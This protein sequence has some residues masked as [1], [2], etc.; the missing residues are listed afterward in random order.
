MHLVE[1]APSAISWNLSE[2]PETKLIVPRAVQTVLLAED[3][4]DLRYV[5]ECSL[6]SMGYAVVACADG[7]LALAAFHSH[8]TIDVLLTDF[9]MPTKSGV[10]LARELTSLRP[11]LPVM[12]ITGSIL[13]AVTRQE[14]RDRRWIY[15]SKPCHL[16]HLESALKTV[17]RT[18]C[19]VAA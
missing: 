9:E 2:I 7:Q 18:E 10:E 14:L 6:R 5:M 19:I 13:P 17:L 12:I 4:D 8:P 15:L 3:N 11:S 16:S 1:A